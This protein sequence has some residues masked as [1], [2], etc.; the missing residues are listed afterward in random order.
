MANTDRSF[1]KK[2]LV[3]IKKKFFAGKR[4]DKSV[5]KE[6]TVEYR[7]PVSDMGKVSI[8]VGTAMRGLLMFCSVFGLTLMFFDSI[9][10]YKKNA[11]FREYT[12]PIVPILSVSLVLC[13]ALAFVKYSKATKIAI[14]IGAAALFV[15]LPTLLYSNPATLYYDA[16][17]TV[18]NETVDYIASSRFTSFARFEVKKGYRFEKEVLVLWGAFAV[19]AILSVIFYFAVCDKARPLIFVTVYFVWWLPLFLFNLPSSNTGF[20]LSAA[21]IF[22]FFVCF[23]C[24][25]RYSGYYERKKEAKEKRRLKKEA[26]ENITVGKKLVNIR[27]KSSA[28][29]VYEKAIE[30]GLTEHK[31]RSAALSVV[32]RLKNE[33]K[34]V[35]KTEKAALKL[36]NKEKAI[37]LKKEKKAEKSR[38]KAVKREV[39]SSKG[40]LSPEAVLYKEKLETDKLKR[41]E[42]KKERFVLQAASGF[43]SFASLLLALVSVWIPAV[44][45]KKSFKT[46]TFIDD[47]VKQLRQ[48]TDDILMSDDVDLTRDDLY[49]FPEVFGYEKLTFDERK[50][51][52]T[53]IYYVESD[54]TGNVYL[55][56]RTALDFDLASDRWTFADNE[57]VIDT[58]RYFDADFSS[59]GITSSAYSVLYSE[60]FSENNLY[61]E[62]SPLVSAKQIHTMRVNGD[63]KLLAVASVSDTEKGLFKRG[64][65]EP[66]EHGYTDYFDGIYT[67]RYYSDSNEGYSTVS[68]L[69]DLTYEKAGELLNAE[70][71][72]IDALKDVSEKYKKGSDSTELKDEYKNAFGSGE[73]YFDVGEKYIY[74]MSAEERSEVDKFLAE[75]LKY[76]EWVYENYTS[77]STSEAIAALAEDLT[78]GT[79]TRHDTVMAV[80]KYLTAGDYKYTLSPVVEENDTEKS[81]LEN[82][83]FDTK[84]G[85]C[86]HFT[87]AAAMLLREIGI[88]V[89]YAEGYIA[90]GWFKGYGNNKVAEYTSNIFDENSH[91][92]IEVYYDGIGWVSYE[93]TPLYAEEAYGDLVTDAEDD[94][95]NSGGDGDE[96]IE[97]TSD[98]EIEK[99]PTVIPDASDDDVPMSALERFKW[100][101]VSVAVILILV[102]IFTAVKV[103]VTK[104]AMAVVNKKYD[105]IAD[106]KNETVFR[107]KSRD[108]REIEVFLTDNILGILRGVGIGPEKGELSEEFGKRLKHDFRGLSTED[109]EVIMEFI[110]RSEFGSS[111][112]FAELSSLAEFLADI[113]VSLYSGLSPMKKFMLRYVKHII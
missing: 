35:S 99:L 1:P 67:S 27:I 59:D 13:V 39:A 98:R 66:S 83:L 2:T 108:K 101:I 9:G 74:E 105:I 80:I 15:G 48:L 54:N 46:V 92:W 33:K 58:E 78:E 11:D 62:I 56:T 22:A 28:E 82:F 16:L 57:K 47:R 81:V 64:S 65:G 12:L 102:G 86:N 32:K 71:V 7:S 53:L 104:R 42:K 72:A 73:F 26:A 19:I 41:K 106:A 34:A 89:R 75:E 40:T 44:S 24:D 31:A 100:L 29:A 6:H 55:K 43:T 70:T 113:T 3:Q 17:R 91:T 45:A 93:T 63:S 38:L 4:V 109:P 112:G 61:S 84:E 21:A 85:Y 23:A 49:S 52:G 68:Y 77:K 69:Y 96:L 60:I 110:R 20:A 37:L 79:Q 10:L 103:T 87:T 76:R 25:R 50:Y 14:P 97:D 107:D 90:R 30:A 51:D 18:W 5:N 95:E 94:R 36:E 88:P 111:L 8:I